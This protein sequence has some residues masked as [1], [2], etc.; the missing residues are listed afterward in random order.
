MSDTIIELKNVIKNYHLGKTRIQAIRGINLE[1]KLGDFMMVKGPSGSG[2]TTL[3]NLVGCLDKPSTGAVFFEGKDTLKLNQNQL[4][5]IRKDKI[6]FVFQHFNLI[7]VLTASENAELP[8][9]LRKMARRERMKRLESLFKNVGLKDK[10]FHRP[11]ELSG[12]E[13]QRVAIVRALAHKPDIV[14]ADE[15]TGDLDSKTG[16]QIVNLMKKMNEEEGTT[17]IISSHDPMITRHAKRIIKLRDGII[18]EE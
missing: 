14:V 3:L 10:V 2:K 12:G 6:G 5:D 4:A 1:I 15:P 17:F 9:L 11:L 18:V 7:P 16:Q 13:Q 8:L